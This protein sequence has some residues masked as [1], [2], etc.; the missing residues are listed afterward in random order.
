[1]WVKI[2]GVT[3]PEAV[4]AALSAGANAIGFVF[5]ASVRRVTPARA[6]ELAAPA[7]GKL[8]C[9]AVTQHPDAAQLEAIVKEFSPD[10]LQTDLEDLAAIRLPGNI[11]ALPVLRAGQRV[12]APLP[13]RAVYEGQVSGTGLTTDWRDAAALST[14]GVELILAGG[15]NPGNVAAAIRAVHPFGVDV[16]SGVEETPGVKSP[17]KIREFVAAARAA[18]RE[19]A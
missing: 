6:R 10:V 11:E 16:S 17:A 3:T 18:S 5:A 15:L 12:P 7:R 8:R 4:D 2:C 19:R 14:A 9:V 1:M 13:R